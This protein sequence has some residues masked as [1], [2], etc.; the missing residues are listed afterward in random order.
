MKDKNCVITIEQTSDDH[1]TTCIYK[2]DDYR[3][4]TAICN[5]LDNVAEVDSDNIPVMNYITKE[6]RKA[7]INDD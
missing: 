5:I 2:L 3:V 6:Y 7:V 1:V 4:A